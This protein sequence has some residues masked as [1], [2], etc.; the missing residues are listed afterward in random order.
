MKCFGEKREAGRG[1]KRSGLAEGVDLNAEVII[2][3]LKLFC[4]RETRKAKN[5][6]LFGQSPAKI[7]SRRVEAVLVTHPSRSRKI[8]S[9]LDLD[10]EMA[11]TN[12]PTSRRDGKAE[13]CVITKQS[14]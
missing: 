12:G 14:I 13:V 5:G 11:G 7:E 8:E 4:H 9:L 2:S 6:G 10:S 3:I 1:G